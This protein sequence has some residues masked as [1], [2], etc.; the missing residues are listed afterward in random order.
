MEGENYPTM[1][2]V[3]PFWMWMVEKVE[4]KVML[5]RIESKLAADL[6]DQHD[7]RMPMISSEPAVVAC[8]LDPRFRQL[9]FFSENDQKQASQ[10]LADRFAKAQAEHAEEEKRKAVSLSAPAAAASSSSAASTSLPQAAASSSAAAAELDVAPPAVPDVAP[11]AA[12]PKPQPGHFAVPAP[13]PPKSANAH[14]HAPAKQTKSKP[15]PKP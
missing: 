15:S 14:K 12:V 2:L 10:W 6:M 7:V 1:N 8:M 5:D 11:P 3:L 4:E 13:K 9:N